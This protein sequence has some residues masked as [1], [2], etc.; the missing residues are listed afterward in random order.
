MVATVL[1]R[2]SGDAVVEARLATRCRR[3]AWGGRRLGSLSD[4]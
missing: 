2:R 4:L 3:P 1:P